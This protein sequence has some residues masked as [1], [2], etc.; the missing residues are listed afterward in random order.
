MLCRT[1]PSTSVKPAVLQVPA[2]RP[3]RGVPDPEDLP[4][5]LVRG[6]VDVA[7][8]VAGLDVGEA[9]VLVR[10]L[11]SSAL[12]SSAKLAP[13]PRARRAG[14]SARCPRPRPSRRGPARRRRGGRRRRARRCRRTAGWCRSGRA[15]PRSSARPGGGSARAGRPAGPARS[16]RTSGAS[17]PWS[18]ADLGRG[19]VGRVAVGHPSRPRAP[20]RA[21]ATGV[22]AGRTG[23]GHREHPGSP[24]HDKWIGRPVQP[25]RA[26][27][28]GGRSA[29]AA[30]NTSTRRSRQVRRPGGKRR[31]ARA[32]RRAS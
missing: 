6:Q 22:R 26:R 14:W 11:G 13:R 9:V 32:S 3:D 8:P 16:V 10:R 23:V 30:A 12:P 24:L 31:R 29:V 17:S 20:P 27:Y 1:G 21:C 7:L 25:G 4:G 28:R 18:A 2:D 15:A 5:A 19:V